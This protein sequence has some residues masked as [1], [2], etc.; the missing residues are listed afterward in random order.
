MKAIVN[1][2]VLSLLA[3]AASA[4]TTVSIHGST[5][6]VSGEFTW[7]P[8]QDSTD[9]ARPSTRYT[10]EFPVAGSPFDADFS[11]PSDV[12]DQAP[13]TIGRDLSVT[14]DNPRGDPRGRAIE[15][16]GRMAAQVFNW[17]TPRDPILR[18]DDGVIT[19]QPVMTDQYL[20]LSGFRHETVGEDDARDITYMHFFLNFDES[21]SRL[22]SV[23]ATQ[24][25]DSSPAGPTPEEGYAAMPHFQVAL[26]LDE[27]DPVDV[28]DLARQS[29]TPKTP[30]P[31]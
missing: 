23:S 11:P 6:R 12:R 8:G 4:T 30:A 14:I 20:G 24:V 7:T 18:P 22:L 10:L 5:V 15:R 31:P 17:E 1:S 13:P 28:S 29:E 9:P 16:S 21:Y 2:I 27:F 19:P 25:I 26:G 3:T